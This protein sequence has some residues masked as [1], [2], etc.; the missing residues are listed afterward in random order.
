MI[1]R[2]VKLGISI[3]S[4]DFKGP[5]FKPMIQE[6]QNMKNNGGGGNLG[7]FQRQ[8]GG[9]EKKKEESIDIFNDA[10]QDSFEHAV[11]QG[12]KDKLDF[13]SIKNFIN[14]ILLKF[15]KF[16]ESKENPFN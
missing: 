9:E 8:Q 10:E 15:K 16:S 14:S 11:Q 3:M 12:D 13:S 6:S 5:S 2:S 4:F 1:L 7:Y